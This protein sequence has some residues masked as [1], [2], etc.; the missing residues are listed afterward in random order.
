[1]TSAYFFDRLRFQSLPKDRG[2]AMLSVLMLIMVLTSLAMLVLGLTLSQSAPTLMQDK[3]VRT[4]AAAQ[5][6]LDA[7]AFQIRH[8]YTSDGVESFGDIHK[9]PCS[10]SGPVEDDLDGPHF[11]VQIRYFKDDPEGQDEEWLEENALECHL[12][13]GASGGLRDVARYALLTAEGFDPEATATQNRADRVLEATY[14][15]QLT[16][17]KIAGGRIWDDNNQY[18]WVA[19]SADPGAPVRYRS[20][21]SG[22]CDEPTELNSWTWANDYMIHLSASDAHGAIP[23][24]LSGR[25]TG[26]TPQPMT[27]R[28]CT[29]T[30]QD[31][32]GQRFA[33]TG[34][35]TWRGQNAANTAPVNSFIIKRSNAAVYDEMPVSVGG[36]QGWKSV[37][38]DPAVGKGNASYETDQVVNHQLFGRCLDVT[39]THI[40]ANYMITYPCKQDPSG[41]DS[42]DWNH[43]WYYNEPEVGQEYVSTKI[44]VVTGGTTYC[45]IAPTSTRTVTETGTGHSVTARFPRFLS[46]VSGGSRNCTSSTTDWKRYGYNDDEALAYHIIDSNGR[47][48]SAAGPRTTGHPLWNTVVVAECTD[49]EAQKWNVP[50]DPVEASLSGYEETTG[51]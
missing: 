46:G 35:H 23:L 47:C 2:A 49:S 44:T 31:P 28:E 45:L 40:D 38:P 22:H 14:T 8:A 18:C 12:G 34:D 42:F 5:A 48:L 32:L 6:G 26:G 39:D 13:A 50:T 36:S 51:R 4:L 43:K 19:D 15:F 27:L 11:D 25:H 16:T 17:R 10:V 33:W 20:G 37:N 1:M 29:S 3:N 30:S 24:C 9:L 41:N 7:A 21:G